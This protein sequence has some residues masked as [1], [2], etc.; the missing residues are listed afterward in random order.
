MMGAAGIEKAALLSSK[1]K[2]NT[3]SNDKEAI[4][5]RVRP[6]GYVKN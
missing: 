5:R 4:Y 1:T 3:L 6:K 2:E